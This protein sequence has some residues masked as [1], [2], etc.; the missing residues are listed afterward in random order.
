MGTENSKPTGSASTSS[1]KPNMNS[2][3]SKTIY[4]QIKKQS[5]DHSQQA[6]LAKANSMKGRV[7]DPL[8]GR[9][10]EN[11]NPKRGDSHSSDGYAVKTFPSGNKYEGEW[12]D[13]KYHGKGKLI[14]A[15]GRQYEGDWFQGVN[16]GKGSFLY[17]NGDRYV[18]EYKG[19][20]QHGQGK[21]L[22]KNGDKYIGQWQNGKRHGKGELMKI[23]GDGFKG[24]WTDGHPDMQ[25]LKN[26]HR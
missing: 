2:S 16:H 21:F 23:N 13:G 18:G 22:W 19:G 12:K 25:L 15:D 20:K 8:T 4:D 11:P 7:F 6:A 9:W 5:D 3:S 14:Y 17:A 24:M 26:V 1:S 10:K